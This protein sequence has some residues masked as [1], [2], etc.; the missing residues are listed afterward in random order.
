[1]VIELLTF[2]ALEL[3]ELG[4]YRAAAEM[5]GLR[6]GERPERGSEGILTHAERLLVAGLIQS[7]T[8]GIKQ[9]GDQVSA[10]EML[11]DSIRLFGSDPRGQVARS[12]LAWSEYWAGNLDRSLALISEV[13]AEADDT[14][15]FRVLLLRAEIYSHQ[16]IP[17]QAFAQLET[18][19][20]LYDDRPSLLKGKFHNQRGRVYRL[21]EQTDRAIVEYTSA[22]HFFE[23]SRNRRCQAIAANNLAGIYLETEQFSQ[24]HEY[25]NQ[26]KL[27]FAELGDKTYEAQ[28]WDQIASI[29]L[30]EDKFEQAETSINTGIGLVERGGV[31]NECLI[32]RD[33]IRE[34]KHGKV[35]DDITKDDSIRGTLP[36]SPTPA[37]DLPTQRGIRMTPLECAQYFLAKNP[38]DAPIIYDM[39]VGLAS[40][41]SKPEHDDVFDEIEEASYAKMEDSARHR[42]EY[43]RRR[44]ITSVDS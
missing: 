26:A 5:L 39:A 28:A 22:I 13:L 1:M 17:D 9:T 14:T 42:A 36:G 15:R 30:A 21:L 31:Q 34:I 11:L 20:T 38:D 43:R 44:L 25:A 24:A 7:V 10:R 12:W 27:L 35:M 32:T 2:S 41:N 37:T 18:A 3:C 23:D 6:D 33:K 29:Y 4:D 19:A 16:G 40:L 8:N